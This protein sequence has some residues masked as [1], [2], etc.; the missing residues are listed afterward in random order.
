MEALV[1]RFPAAVQ[2]LLQTGTIG[3]DQEPIDLVC[4]S[5]ACT[6]AS[7]LPHIGWVS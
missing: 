4:G 7:V 2:E 3:A 6:S 5:H 1:H